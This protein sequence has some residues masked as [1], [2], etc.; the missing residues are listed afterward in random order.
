MRNR[1]DA[2]FAAKSYPTAARQFEELAAYEEKA[3]EL[4]GFDTA[5]HGALLA[6]YSSLKAEE[7]PRLTAFE[8]ADARQALKWVGARYLAKFPRSEHTLEVKFNI[9]RA[10]YDDGEFEESGE[11]FKAFAL[12]H[13]EYK[14]AAVAGHLALDSFRQRNDFKGLEATG[15]AFL[16]P[17]GSRL[18]P[19]FLAEVRQVITQSKSDALGELA[20]QS[21]QEAGG[22][23]MEG[24]I[25]VA[26][27]NKGGEL[28]EK[29]LYGAFVAA[30]EKRDLTKERELGTRLVQEYPKSGYLQDVLLS[31]GRQL[32]EVARFS[33]AASQFELLGQKLGSLDGWLSAARL[34]LALQEYREATRDFEAAAD[35]GGPRK[36]ELLAQL[37]QSRLKA[38]E[39]A[40][41]RISAEAAL[42]LAA[43]V[44]AEVQAKAAASSPEKPDALIKLLTTVSQGPNGQSEEGARGLW[45]LGE[46]LFR[47]YKRLLEG[48]PGSIDAKVAALQSLEGVFTQAAQ[49]GSPEWAV[50]SLWR[51]ALAYQALSESVEK[52]PAPPGLS[53]VET[54]QFKT[55]V[56][57]QAAQLKE[58]AE[59]A[60][61]ACESRA[62]SLEVFTEAAVGCRSRSES[63]KSPLPTGRPP[64]G[65]S[66][67]G[68]A[69]LQQKVETTGDAASLEALGLAYLEAG[70]LPLAQLT[71]GRATELEDSRAASH[72]GLGI[73]AL[74]LGDAMTARAA[75]G[76]A[77][78]ADPGFEK[79][80][81]N[82]GA[83]RCRYGDSEGAKRELSQVK[84]GSLS[85]ADV[86]P[87]WK[88]CR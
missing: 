23:V 70:Q 81:A 54:Q 86:D 41:A 20:L 66:G 72:N 57:D 6:H 46:V 34:R 77:L 30:R 18:P 65:S 44:V 32:A 15:R 53:A 67:P 16:S 36:A 48:G 55:A 75:F 74:F 68:V 4:K 13:P 3:R 47:D 76:K 8:V 56:K 62:I 64:A 39:P 5:L 80:R 59:G 27:E 71:L 51:I 7:V 42:R 43:A 11:L 38:K 14:D 33:E 52:T 45:Y 78:E 50:A 2:L 84:S 82:L 19:A 49:M 69:A 31:L 22:D 85:G 40:A 29:A 25:K 10:H 21:S 12:S 61:K 60:F 28:G 58:R 26:D 17:S 1:A 88:G 83:L 79:A 37:A 9:A 24:L 87:D 73:A 35:L 63:A